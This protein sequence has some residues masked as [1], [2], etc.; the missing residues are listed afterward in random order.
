MSLL[1]Y[2][3]G[4]LG[5]W[6]AAR[7]GE[8]EAVEAEALALIAE[9]SREGALWAIREQMPLVQSDASARRRLVALHA[10]ILRLAPRRHRGDTAT[11]MLYRSP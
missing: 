11:R 6:R 9:K 5:R 7:Q 4:P 10:A 2:L 8:A 1:S 3:F